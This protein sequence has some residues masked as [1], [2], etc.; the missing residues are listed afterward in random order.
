[1]TNP[2]PRCPRCQDE[3]AK[4]DQWQQAND[5]KRVLTHRR[6]LA[7]HIR[8]DHKGYRWFW[9]WHQLRWIEVT[10]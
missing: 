1:M 2:F 6:I 9:D 8:K 3:Q 10:P 4:I 5:T 7:A